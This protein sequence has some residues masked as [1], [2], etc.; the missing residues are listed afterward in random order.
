MMEKY[1]R[2]M[3]VYIYKI[4]LWPGSQLTIQSEVNNIVALPDFSGQNLPNYLFVLKKKLLE[5]KYSTKTAEK[6]AY[7]T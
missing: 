6:M 4:K 7:L 2:F 3:N 5:G 1:Q